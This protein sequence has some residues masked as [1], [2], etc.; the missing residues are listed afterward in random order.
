MAGARARQKKVHFIGIG[1]IGMSALAR[2]FLAQ[3][4]TGKRGEKWAVS[5]S[6]LTPS[7]ITRE[8]QKE[9]VK[10]NFG[11]KKGNIKA[12]LTLIIRSQA[13][14]ADNPELREATRLGLPTITYPEAVGVLVGSH[15]T[16]AVAGAHGKSTTATLIGLILKKAA[17]DPTIIVGTKLREL[18][19]KNFRSGRGPYL[20]LEADEFGR[21]FLNYSPTLTVVTN[22]D[23]EHLDTY[24]N[25]AGVKKAFLQF[26]ARTKPGGT[27]ILNKDDKNLFSLRP[28]IKRI[29]QNRN[30]K[31]LWYSVHGNTA[32]KIKEVIKI[33][34]VHNISNAVAA[35]KAGRALGISHKNIVAAISA[36][37]GPA[38]F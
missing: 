36:Y 4:H 10:V 20:V 13:V 26:L 17:L 29:A 25:L 24:K 33:P 35:Y 9:G 28:K 21:A 6:D 19:D 37:R 27:L 23:K 7:R 15:K 31:I 22:I 32:K 38:P 3:N 30:L 12:D 2:W 5:G 8:L 1:G 34:G 18:G 11:H 14:K 16:I